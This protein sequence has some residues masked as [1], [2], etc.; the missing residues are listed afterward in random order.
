MIKQNIKMTQYIKQVA[1]S[2][3][4]NSTILEYIFASDFQIYKHLASLLILLE[5]HSSSVQL[6][7][8][9]LPGVILKMIFHIG[10]IKKYV[11]VIH[12]HTH[13]H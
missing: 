6:R 2:Y 7:C 9:E 4:N 3:F 10:I 12:T 8:M 1:V 13:I 5:G 11:Y